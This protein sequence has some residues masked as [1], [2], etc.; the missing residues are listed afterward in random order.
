MYEPLV[1]NKTYRILTLE[2]LALGRDYYSLF[3]Q[4]LKNIE[5]GPLVIDVLKSY[6]SSQ[7]PIFKEENGRIEVIGEDDNDGSKSIKLVASSVLVQLVFVVL[8]HFMTF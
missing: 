1:T 5:Q 7:S 4:H 6:L 8:C 3:S 2:H